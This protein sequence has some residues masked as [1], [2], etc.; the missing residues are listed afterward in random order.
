MSELAAIKN[1]KVQFRPARHLRIQWQRFCEEREGLRRKL[2]SNIP[3]D[4]L[5]QVL[6]IDMASMAKFMTKTLKYLEEKE[7]ESTEKEN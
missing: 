5:V 4:Q 3:P 6:L 2:P 1:L 7:R